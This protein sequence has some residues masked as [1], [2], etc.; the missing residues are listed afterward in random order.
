M[1]SLY[2]KALSN[3]RYLI[4]IIFNL[5]YELHL[6]IALLCSQNSLK[7]ITFHLYYLSVQQSGWFILIYLPEGSIKLKTFY[8]YYLLSLLWVTS[9]HCFTLFTKL[10]Q[11]N[12]ILSMLSVCTEI[13]LFYIHF[14][15]RGLYQTEDISSIISLVSTVSYS[16]TLFWFIHKIWDLHIDFLIPQALSNWRHF[17]NIILSIY[18][19][20]EL[21]IV[22][23]YP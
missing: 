12:Y 3:Q 13:W 10:S 1:I 5:Y 16:F 7:P 8:Q 20:L 14:L 9:L 23:I 2:H 19:E 18:Y 17:I 4:N 6:Y 15:T 11:T 22:F 21:Y